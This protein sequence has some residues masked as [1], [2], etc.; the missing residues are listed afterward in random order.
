MMNYYVMTL[1][2]EM[3]YSGLN[4]SIIGRAMEKNL[5]SLE[6]VDIRKYTKY[7]HWYVDDAR[8]VGGAGIVMQAQS[9]YDCYMDLC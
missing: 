5:L 3:V 8:Y 7:I 2:P 4:T 1:F 6:C 9:I